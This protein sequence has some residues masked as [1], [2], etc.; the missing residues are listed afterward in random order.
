MASLL[1]KRMDTLDIKYNALKIH[2]CL[3]EEDFLNQFGSIE[4]FKKQQKQKIRKSKL[5]KII[6]I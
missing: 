5:L 1:K 2:G 4:N 3:S 6:Q